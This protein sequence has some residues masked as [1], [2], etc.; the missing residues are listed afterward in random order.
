MSHEIGRWVLLLHDAGSVEAL[1][2]YGQ[3]Y[4]SEASILSSRESLSL[5]MPLVPLSV[6]LYIRL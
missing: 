3:S 5:G 4:W 6:R 1:V 2:M